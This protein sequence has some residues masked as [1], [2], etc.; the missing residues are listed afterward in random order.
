MPNKSTMLRNETRF[1]G[2][3]NKGSLKLIQKANI[4]RIDNLFYIFISRY[5]NFRFLMYLKSLFEHKDKG[6]HWIKAKGMVDAV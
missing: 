1:G 6:N 5:R 4:N 3:L 2:K